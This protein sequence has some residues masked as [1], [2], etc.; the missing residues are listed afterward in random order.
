MFSWIP[1]FTIS[2]YGGL[3]LLVFLFLL[4]VLSLYKKY[5]GEKN[6]FNCVFIHNYIKLINKAYLI[7]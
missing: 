6:S 4:S 2:S 5:N 7:N 3:A 1:Q